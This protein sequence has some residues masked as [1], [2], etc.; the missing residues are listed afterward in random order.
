MFLSFI[1]MAYR[2]G[3]C[4]VRS[5]DVCIFMALYGVTTLIEIII[6]N[7]GWHTLNLLGYAC[8]VF[9]T[10]MTILGALI[11]LFFYSVQTDELRDYK[12]RRFMEITGGYQEG[13]IVLYVLNFFTGKIQ[14]QIWIRRITGEG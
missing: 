7:P 6:A 3:K 10:S 9:S 4:V 1:F 5:R 8:T 2:V 11:C 14:I 13:W 12:W